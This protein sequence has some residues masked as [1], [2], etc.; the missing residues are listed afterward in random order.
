MTSSLLDTR[1]ERGDLDMC[2]MGPHF[3]GEECDMD[4]PCWNELEALDAE[5]PVD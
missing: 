5:D 1:C 3:H 4:C 2:G